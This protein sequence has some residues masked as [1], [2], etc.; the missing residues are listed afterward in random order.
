MIYNNEG[1]FSYLKNILEIAKET[2][3][4]LLTY[5][6]TVWPFDFQHWSA[7]AQYFV[8]W[9]HKIHS[10]TNLF[11]YLL[12]H[13]H[14]QTYLVILSHSVNITI[15]ITIN[16]LVA[17]WLQTEH[18]NITKCFVFNV[19]INVFIVFTCQQLSVALTHIEHEH[20]EAEANEWWYCTAQ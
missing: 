14:I 13:L 7:F 6:V 2:K 4:P 10:H 16:L 3:C 8:H 15:D 9:K 1:F 11:C 20:K 19:I 5:N 18:N 12:I 17:R